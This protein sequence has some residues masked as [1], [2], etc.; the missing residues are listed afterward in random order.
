MLREP[1]QS[2]LHEGIWLGHVAFAFFWWW[3]IIYAF[4]PTPWLCNSTHVCNLVVVVDWC[5]ARI[6]VSKCGSRREQDWFDVVVAVLSSLRS[7][8]VLTCADIYLPITSF[9]LL[10]CPT[11]HLVGFC[12]PLELSCYS[13]RRSSCPLIKWLCSRHHT[14]GRVLLGT[15]SSSWENVRLL[16]FLCKFLRQR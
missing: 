15:H 3:W 6:L 10:V 16:C 9:L 4:C 8:S 1:V 5:G 7:M 2:K 11:G 14:V 12:V 13:L